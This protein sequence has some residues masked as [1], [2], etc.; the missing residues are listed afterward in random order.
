MQNPG[1]LID[2]L[3]DELRNCDRHTEK[4]K[5]LAEELDLKMD[6]KQ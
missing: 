4:T 1:Q 6:K 2:E 3:K 5:K